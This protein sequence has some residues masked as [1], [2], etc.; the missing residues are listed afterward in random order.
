MFVKRQRPVEVAQIH[1][2]ALLDGV[3]LLGRYAEAR[4]CCTDY[5]RCCYSGSVYNIIEVDSILAQNN[6]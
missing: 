1:T 6:D 3:I 4:S 2:I 5:G